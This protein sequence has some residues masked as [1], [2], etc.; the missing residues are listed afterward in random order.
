MDLR[1]VSDEFEKMPGVVGCVDGTYVPMT[2]KSGEKRNAYICRKGF[3]AMHAQI[4]CTNNLTIT[5]ITT[6]YPGSVHDA[7]VFRNSP[8]FR[9]CRIYL[10]LIM[11]L[12]TPLTL[13][14]LTYSLCLKTMENL[15][16]FKKDTTTSIH[17]QGAV[18]SAASAYWRG[19][20]GNW[21][22]STPETMF[23]CATLLLLVQLCTTLSLCM[24][25][26]MLTTLMSMMTILMVC[27]TLITRPVR[28]V[29]RS[30]C[31]SLLNCSIAST[32]FA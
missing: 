29:C 8:Y 22:T 27:S 20:F 13:W 15:L 28:A 11:Y 18:L 19:N 16:K 7:R 23:W 26:S 32:W 6:G 30:V 1:S 4:T 3:P 14:K 5:D 17:H 25:Q 10:Q 9:S 24:K 31:T 21:R 2:G 12:L